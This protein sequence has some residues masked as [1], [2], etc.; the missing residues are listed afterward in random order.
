MERDFSVFVLLVLVPIFVK[1]TKEDM[2]GAIEANSSIMEGTDNDV[3]V[4]VDFNDW[5]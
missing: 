2:S 3:N 4:C 1:V 5:W